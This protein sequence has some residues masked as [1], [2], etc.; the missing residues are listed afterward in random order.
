MRRLGELLR[1]PK[2]D[3]ADLVIIEAGEI[4]SEAHGEIQEM[5][6]V[7]DFAVGLSRRLY[8]RTIASE[9][10]GHR[11]AETWHPLGVVGDLS[12]FD[13]PAAVW[14]WNTVVA[15]VSAT[16]STRMGREVGPRVAAASAAACW[17]SPATTPR[18][19]PRPP[20]WTSPSRASSSPR[21]APRASAAPPCAAS[22]STVTSPTPS[23]SG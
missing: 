2:S 10:S 19:S 13:F 12:A 3:L 15:L 8:G 6:D 9:R 1:E 21:R 4:R 16:G 23:S 11:L 18:S 22:S 17:N 14:S 7:C 5:I 20:T